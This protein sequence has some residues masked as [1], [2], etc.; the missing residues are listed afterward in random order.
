ML[1]LLLDENLSPEIARQIALKRVDIPILSLHGWEGGWFKAKPDD[2]I[3]AAAFAAG[4]T[5]VTYDQRTILPTLVQ[6][7]AAGTPHGGVIFVDD[8]T[9]AP[10]NFGALVRLLIAMW[11]SG[12]GEDWMDRVEYLSFR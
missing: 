8:L 4:L 7:G 3:L 12:R 6:W 11:E 9:I 1:S 5:L 10:N 2:L